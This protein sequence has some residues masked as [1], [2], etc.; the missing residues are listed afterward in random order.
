MNRS[1]LF[2][3]AC[4][5][6][7]ACVADVEPND[8][9]QLSE[10]EVRRCGWGHGGHSYVNVEW[11]DCERIRVTS[12]SSIHTITVRVGGEDHTWSRLGGRG[13][14]IHKPFAT[15]VWVDGRH[16]SRPGG[17]HDPCMAPDPTG[18]VRGLIFN[19]ENLNGILEVG[20]DGVEGV[21]VALWSDV[22][23]DGTPD[24]ELT[25]T[26]TD[27][28]GTYEFSGLDPEN[29]IVQLVAPDGYTISPM[30]AGPER[31]DSDFN[32]GGISDTVTVEGGDVIEVDGGIARPLPATVGDCVWWDLDEDGLQEE[33]EAGAEGVTVNLWVDEDDDGTPDFILDT[34][35]TSDTGGYLFR[36]LDASLKYIIQVVLPEDYAV[37]P[38]DVGGDDALDSDANED[39]LTDVFML[40]PGS[41]DVSYDVGLIEADEP[42]P[43]PPTPG[44][45]GDKVF[46][47]D[48]QNGVQD[49][50]EPG[51][52]G[53][54]VTLWTVNA[55]GERVEAIATT[56]TNEVG[57]YLFAD[58]DT[59]LR[60]QVQWIVVNTRKFTTRFVG[61]PASD[62]NADEDGYSDIVE[63]ASGENNLSID[64]GI[65]STANVG[66]YVWNDADRDGVQDLSETGVG[67]ITVNLW[68]VDAAGNPLAIIARTV[69]A[70]TGS[71]R[72]LNVVSTTDYKIQFILPPGA[73]F[74]ARGVGDPTLDSN[75][76]ADGITEVLMLTAGTFD[77]SVDCGIRFAD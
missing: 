68:T 35:I 11:L 1:I 70:P 24:E 25:S 37:S 42:P 56:E 8:V 26:T 23:A 55:A 59:S 76:D 75:V 71:Y 58:L 7:V 49:R 69:T 72:F 46:R 65:F 51:V 74:T 32:D 45:I 52:E 66:D 13:Y 38:K 77:R 62:S 41:R 12:S 64:A 30:D 17:D 44:S 20:E 2:V 43:P 34:Q 39:G 31:I 63:L 4:L 27:R 18:T 19:D 48:N 5:S 40:R 28:N 15:D 14:V 36:N 47:D 60:Y 54:L 57:E 33:G 3:V 73:T 9:V 22:D 10:A 50:V 61:D 16:F 29:Y 53:I 6:A 67:G 21:T